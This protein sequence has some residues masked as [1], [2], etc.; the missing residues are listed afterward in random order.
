MFK[1]RFQSSKNCP[2][3]FFLGFWLD[4]MEKTMKSQRGWFRRIVDRRNPA[5]QLMIS[6]IFSRYFLIYI[7]ITYIYIYIHTIPAIWWQKRPG[8]TPGVKC[9]S[10]DFWSITFIRISGDSIAENC[11]TTAECLERFRGFQTKHPNSLSS[12]GASLIQY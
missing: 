4:K 5:K 7:D 1:F 3:D 11:Q 2:Y 6:C 8:D 12:S 10:A 9:F